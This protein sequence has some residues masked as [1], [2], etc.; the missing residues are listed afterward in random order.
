MEE[1]RER[2]PSRRCSHLGMAGGLVC[3]LD[4]KSYASGSMA[5]GRITQAGL[6]E[7]QEEER[8]GPPGWGLRREAS[9]LTLIK[10]ASLQKPRRGPML[11]RQRK[12]VMMMMMMR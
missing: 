8:R 7:G 5:T 9:D 12:G 11:H 10:S 6:V 1:L 4:P 2:K 3:S